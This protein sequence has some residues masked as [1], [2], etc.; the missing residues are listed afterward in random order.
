MPHLRTYPS[1]ITFV[2]LPNYHRIASTKAPMN[3][4][5]WMVSIHLPDPEVISTLPLRYNDYIWYVPP[6]ASDCFPSHISVTAFTVSIFQIYH[7]VVSINRPSGYEPDA[8][9]LRHDDGLSLDGFDPSPLGSLVCDHTLQTGGFDP[10]PLI[11]PVCVHYT[12]MMCFDIY[13]KCTQPSLCPSSK[14]H[15]INRPLD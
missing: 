3:S 12:T 11:P 1:L 9:P 4:C 10:P 2:A 8:L 6:S 7:R 15:C 13:P 5:H 14:N